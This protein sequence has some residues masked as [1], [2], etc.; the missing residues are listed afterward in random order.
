MLPTK[1]DTEVNMKPYTHFTL[2]E[3]ANPTQW[4]ANHIL[5]I[6]ID[7]FVTEAKKPI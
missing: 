1:T 2:E 5:I 4:G 6:W 3:E 7:L